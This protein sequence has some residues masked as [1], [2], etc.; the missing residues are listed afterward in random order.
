MVAIIAGWQD[1]KRGKT[2]YLWAILTDRANRAA[3]VKEGWTRIGKVFLVAILLDLLYQVVVLEVY[4]CEALVV[5]VLLAIAP[6]VIVRGIVTQAAKADCRQ[7]AMN[8]TKLGLNDI[9]ALDRTRLAAERT[10]MGWIRTSFSMM[11]F[12]FTIYKVMQEVGQVSATSATPVS[13]SRHLGL[14]LAGLGTVALMIACVQH[15]R[16]TRQLRHDEVS[17]PWDLTLVVASLVVCLGLLI[18]GGLLLRFGP[19]T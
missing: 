10:L 2:P 17:A 13:E 5:A 6:Y 1:A 4:P 14:V 16:Y 8:E 7:P 12:G 15:W 9:L 18:L 3:L 11:T 19:F